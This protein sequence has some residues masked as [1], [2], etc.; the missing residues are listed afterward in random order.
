MLVFLDGIIQNLSPTSSK[1][2][3]YSLNERYALLF[4]IPLVLYPRLLAH[5]DL[6]SY[7]VGMKFKI[8]NLSDGSQKD[9]SFEELSISLT[10]NCIILR[11]KEEGFESIGLVTHQTLVF[12]TVEFAHYALQNYTKK[13]LPEAQTCIDLVYKWIKDQ[14]S[15]SNEELKAAA[16]AAYYAVYAAADAAAA[17][18]AYAAAADAA[19]ANAAIAAYRAA[20]AAGKNRLDEQNRQG[21]FILNF[22]GVE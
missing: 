4:C 1:S 7:I 14:S 17:D 19:Y 11:V 22:F 18:A 12:F 20:D 13:I 8:I 6:T 5:S 16:D 21:T 10:P 3:L 15:V 2:Q 9:C